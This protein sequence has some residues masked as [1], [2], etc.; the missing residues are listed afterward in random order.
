MTEKKRILI[1]IESY[2][3]GFKNGGHGR[4]ISN[5]VDFYSDKYDFYIYT[6]DRDLGDKTPYPDIE[7]T[8]WY[9]VNY[10]RVKY[11]NPTKLWFSIGDVI[12]EKKIDIVFSCGLFSN[13]TLRLLFDIWSKRIN[14]PIVI[15]P[16]GQFG[17]NAL[18][19]KKQI[20]MSILKVLKRSNV[21]ERV[22][23]S[24]TSRFEEVDT[25]KLLGNVKTY[26]NEDLPFRFDFDLSNKNPKI[27]GNLNAVFVSRIHPSKNLMEAIHTLKIVS[28]DVKLDIYGMI[29]NQTYWNDCKNEIMK[30][31]KNIKVSYKGSIKPNE[32]SSI[33]SKYD[34]FIFP[35]LG[36]NY[37][38]VIFESLSGACLPII[39]DQTPWKDL[40]SYACGSIYPL[41]DITKATVIVQQYVDMESDTLLNKQKNALAY[42]KKRFEEKTSSHSFSTMIGAI[43]E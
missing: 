24:V 41:G 21:L 31:P 14:T 4:T 7:N 2:L 25:L 3:P 27:V 16:M 22:N 33:F 23:W 5:L 26:I 13:Y 34:V 42:Y 11:N 37:G 38:H 36:E 18:K 35:T 40:E 29:E 43:L 1:L 6:S 8:K 17:V 9:D 30:L 19:F 32:V 20:K 39:S 15:A 12:N 28:G 10:S